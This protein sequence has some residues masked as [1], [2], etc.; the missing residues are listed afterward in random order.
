MHATSIQVTMLMS[1]P[2]TKELLVE[3]AKAQ[4]REATMV[5]LGVVYEG[6]ALENTR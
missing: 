6:V 2:T 3:T 1:G 4:A 5:I